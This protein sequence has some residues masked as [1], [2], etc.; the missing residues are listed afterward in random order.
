MEHSSALLDAGSL[1]GLAPNLL[2]ELVSVNLIVVLVGIAVLLLAL[3]VGVV[4][5][6]RQLAARREADL[7]RDLQEQRHDIERREHRLA[8]REERLDDESKRLQDESAR[9]ETR[10][11]ELAGLEEERRAVLERTASLTAD[12]A[13]QELISVVEHDARIQA[14]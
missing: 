2:A 11:T 13:K 6:S 14:A 7:H 8:E 12:E 9:L 4:L 10:A 5:L 3:S 1:V